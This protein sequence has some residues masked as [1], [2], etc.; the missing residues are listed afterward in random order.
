[1]RFDEAANLADR[2]Q[3]NP[4]KLLYVRDQALEEAAKTPELN[5]SDLSSPS[6]PTRKSC[7]SGKT[8][9]RAG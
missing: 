6:I 1:M 7:C 3:I 2:V 4:D 9:L 8:I 5:S